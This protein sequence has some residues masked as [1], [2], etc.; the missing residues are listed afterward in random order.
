MSIETQMPSENNTT[1]TERLTSFLT[2]HNEKSLA[3]ILRRLNYVIA[4]DVLSNSESGQKIEWVNT[5]FYWINELAEILDPMLDI[6][7]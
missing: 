7:D 1:V 5:G 6:E 2:Q 4:T 3:K